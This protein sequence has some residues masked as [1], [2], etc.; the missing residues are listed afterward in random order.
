MVEMKPGKTA[1]EQCV[2][3][4]DHVLQCSPTIKDYRVGDGDKEQKQSGYRFQHSAT[5]FVSVSR[6]GCQYST[7]SVYNE[8]QKM[9]L[10]KVKLV[11]I[12]LFGKRKISWAIS[13]FRG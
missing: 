4:F 8:C 12:F 3:K 7:M 1:P 6:N 2:R 11:L 10:P 5:L 9:R 13:R